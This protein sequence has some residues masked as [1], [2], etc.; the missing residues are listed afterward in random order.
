VRGGA[1][2]RCWS[3][4]TL[5][6]ILTTLIVVLFV[7]NL[8]NTVRAPW[9][10]AR[11]A[12]TIGLAHGYTIC[13]SQVRGP[14]FSCIYGPLSYFAYLPVALLS[15]PLEMF[16]A[17]SV[18]ATLFL[19][20]PPLLAWAHYRQPV[21][22][23]RHG[24]WILMLF[25]FTFLICLKPLGY[26]AGYIAADSP[27]ICL[28]AVSCW[29]LYRARD[30]ADNRAAALSSL[31]LVLG[32]GS[33]QNTVVVAPAVLV[34]LLL[35]YPRR[36]VAR[37]CG[38]TLMWG[39]AAFGLIFLVYRDLPA[40]YLNTV[41]IPG[42]WPI[43]RTLILRAAHRLYQDSVILLL[44]L[45]GILM[46]GYLYERARASAARSWNPRIVVFFAGAVSLL[47]GSIVLFAVAG[48]AENAFAAYLYL[49]LFGVLV[50]AFE[51]LVRVRGA[52]A[53]RVSLRNWVLVVS[54]LMLGSVAPLRLS[55]FSLEQLSK[56]PP[57]L[58]AYRY[59]REQPGKV[60]FPSNPVATFL[61]EG[62]FYHSEWGV[63]NLIASGQPLSRRDVWKYVPRNARAV[64]YPK[65]WE[66][67]SLLEFIAPGRIPIAD[68]KL[69][70]F[71]LFRIEW[72]ETR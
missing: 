64:A 4:S 62:V 61:A 38:F 46:I 67:D 51:L 18:L 11:L 39:A 2:F 53:H 15:R 58:A 59:S 71:E 1:E 5:L 48:G 44:S 31:M 34:I 13:Q 35:W 27:S 43:D 23:D 3:L 14:L 6:G 41:V 24:P 25:F 10:E 42:H 65:G 9:F 30:G 52:P 45:A 60:Y 26:A 47:P 21:G 69:A 68:G 7:V 40:L 55:P 29:I 32:I 56:W 20:A 57:G 63:M 72:P 19:C 12:P 54:I 66:S 70:E 33:K 36:F 50:A 17:G 8:L 28:L 37:Y 49:L 16:L 22:S